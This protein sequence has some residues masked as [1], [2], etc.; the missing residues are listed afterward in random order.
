MSLSLNNTK[1]HILIFSFLCTLIIFNLNKNS[2]LSPY[3]FHK[4]PFN[5]RN[6]ITTEDVNNRCK[7]TPKKFL[8]NYNKT[9][10][11][12]KN[13]S[14]NTKKD[15]YQDALEEIIGEEQFGN[16]KKYLPRILI[17]V[18]FL[19]VDILF[20][21]I[22]FV[23][24]GC[25]CCSKK[26]KANGCSRFYFFLFFI[27]SVITIIICVYGFII[28]PDIYKTTNAI[29]CSF[30]KLIIH[31]IEGAKGDYQGNS[32]EGLE[33]INNKIELYNDADKKLDKLEENNIC[34]NINNDKYCNFF[35]EILGELTSKNSKNKPFTDH[36][37]KAKN[38]IDSISE[39]FNEIN[40]STLDGLEN[41]MTIYDKYCKLG[42]FILFAA[43]LA[44]CLFGLLTLTSYYICN[45]NCIICLFHLFWNIEMLIIIV[46]ILSGVAFGILGV[47]SKDFVKILEYEKSSDG[48]KTNNNSLFNISQDSLDEIDEC[49]NGKGDLYNKLFTPSVTYDMNINRIYSDF[50]IKYSD[51]KTQ[52]DFTGNQELSNS[53]ND[54]NL[55]MKNIKDLNEYFNEDN[56]KNTLNC[57][58]FQWDFDILTNELN[59]SFA[60][61]YIFFSMV[62]IIADLASFLSI[63][64]GIIVSNYKVQNDPEVSDSNDKHIKMKPNDIRYNMDS[65]SAQIKK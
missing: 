22:W 63:M 20:I 52:S 34:K 39:T 26:T 62:I 9:D 31:F 6:L 8:E 44:F 36:L 45:C 38:K 57:K 65:S 41:I 15:R 16:I 51:Y 19:I 46:T 13:E 59:S 24:C 2:N 50:N 11:Q 28:T 7:N 54:L 47:V 61:K 18:I 60:K 27:F 42:L 49:F 56:L 3:S 43:I 21:I 55:T 48:L 40:N 12:E 10:H 17:Y 1:I 4:L 23:F 29:A 64:F 33:E 25:C 14:N 37:Q 5:L 35:N 32:W 53:F 30:Y 58:F